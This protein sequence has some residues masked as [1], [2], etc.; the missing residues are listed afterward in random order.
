MGISKDALQGFVSIPTSDDAS[1]YAQV[2]SEFFFASQGRGQKLKQRFEVP[3]TARFSVDA[4]SETI[5]SSCSTSATLRVNTALVAHGNASAIG[6][7][8]ASAESS[9]EDENALRFAVSYRKCASTDGD[10][11]KKVVESEEAD[12]EDEQA[13]DA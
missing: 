13:S 12:D 7:S 4:P 3:G 8:T 6:F 5:W 1:N 11:E 9:G 10:E 2:T